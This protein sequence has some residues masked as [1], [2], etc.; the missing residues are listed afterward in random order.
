[1]DNDL[2]A[3]HARLLDYLGSGD[4]S[5][6]IEEWLGPPALTRIAA[7]SYSH[8]NGFRK[9]V[10]EERR[11]GTKLRVHHWPASGPSRTSNVHNH[12]WSFASA[13]MVGALRSTWLTVSRNG[14]RMQ[15]YTFEPAA[16][17]EEHN[18]SPS[19]SDG[20]A[21][22]HLAEFSSGSSY[23]VNADQL[24]RIEALPGTISLML[25]GPAERRWT[26]V[27]RPPAATTQPR[28]QV[29]L[30]AR[31]VCETLESLRAGLVT[32][33][34]SRTSAESPASP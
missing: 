14:D 15:R 30:A 26:H 33:L 13:I 12:R 10:L 2:T 27:Y 9:L 17:G 1:M 32:D 20:L 25:S 5:A 8:P 29:P 22:T 21:V 28:L 6:H 31:E 23:V 16:A 18:L 4:F 34:V 3:L 7:A 11:D 24:H 19:G